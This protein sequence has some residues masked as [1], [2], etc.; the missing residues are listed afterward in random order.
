MQG[1][2]AGAAWQPLPTDYRTMAQELIVSAVVES[3]G[4]QI[5]AHAMQQ[6]VLGSRSARETVIGTGED[7]D[8][9]CVCVTLCPSVC[10]SIWQYSLSST[11]SFDR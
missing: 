2:D 5:A 4:S 3:A 11:H 1:L 10:L 6:I 7:V 9:V 8:P